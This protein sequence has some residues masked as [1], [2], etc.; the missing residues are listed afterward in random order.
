[1]SN[2]TTSDELVLQS[3]SP[4]EFDKSSELFYEA[5]RLR[6]L[7]SNEV[8]AEK[9]YREAMEATGSYGVFYH[10]AQ[11]QIYSMLGNIEYA[12][13]EFEIA[14]EINDQ[15]DSVFID[16][17]LTYRKIA[18]RLRSFNLNDKA[19]A[20][21]KESV[22]ALNRAIGINP[23]NA[24][25]WSA[26]ATTY[27]KMGKEYLDKAGTCITRARELDPQ[28]YLALTNLANLRQ[29][30]GN[31]KEA[32]QYA[33]AAIEMRPN[34]AF[35]YGTIGRIEYIEHRFKEAIDWFEK[36]ITIEPNNSY[37]LSEMGKAYRDVGKFQGDMRSC[38]EAVNWF[39]KA[40]KADQEGDEKYGFLGNR[41]D[42]YRLAG[43]PALAETDLKQALRIKP[44]HSFSLSSLRD[45]YIDL[46]RHEEA[47]HLAK[48]VFE[49]S[50]TPKNHKQY[51]KLEELFNQDKYKSV[52]ITKRLINSNADVDSAKTR[53][54]AEEALRLYSLNHDA[55]GTLGR[56]HAAA[57]EFEAARK[58]LEQALMLNPGRSFYRR[59]L[60][61]VLEKLGEWRAAE[62]EYRAYIARFPH[63]EVCKDGLRR[64]KEHLQQEDRRKARSVTGAEIVF[65]NN[66]TGR[67]ERHPIALIRDFLYDRMTGWNLPIREVIEQIGD[68]PVFIIAKTGVG[69]TVTVPT[70]VLLGLCDNLL[71]EGAD[72]AQRFPQVYVVEPRIPICSMTMAE[73]NDGYQNYVAYRMTDYPEFRDYLVSEGVENVRSKEQNDVSKIVEL[74][75]K[76]VATGKAPYDPHHFNLYGCIT[77]A[78]G[79]INADA[80]I[81]FIT[82]GIME[83]L[84]FEGTELDPKYH[85]II[86]DEAHVTIEAN[87]AIEL[88]IALARKR[89]VKI[90]YMSAT[91]DPAT[92]S[93]DLGVKIVYAEAQR[94]PIHLTNLKAT[95]EES[96]LDLVENFLLN[97]DESRF[98]DPRDFA[99]PLVRAKVERVRLHLL[100]LDDVAD[101]GRIYPGLRNRPQ[102]MLVIVNSHQSENSDTHRIADLIA[103]AEFNRG[104]TRVH[105]LRL[106]SPVVRDP[107]QKLAFDRL[108][109]SIED[110]NGRYVIVATNVVEMGLTFSSLDYVVTMDA[111]FDSEFVDGSQMIRKVELGVNA[112]YQR[113]GRVGRVRPGMAF[114]ARD[115]GASYCA[116]DDETLAAGLPIAPI[117]Y[118]LAKGSF[119]KLALYSFRERMSEKDLRQQIA[120]LNL[121]SRIQENSELWSRFLAERSRLRRIGVAH[122]EG[123]TPAGQAALRFIGLDDMDFAY[124]LATVIER[125]GT[126]SDLAVIF[127]VI[128]ASSE[129]GFED[130]MARRFFL[131]NPKQLSAMEIFHED[132]LGVSVSEAYDLIKQYEFDPRRLHEALQ[133]SGV[134]EQLCSDIC[135]FVRAGYKLVKREDVEQ[136]VSVSQGIPDVVIP[137]EADSFAESEVDTPED[138]AGGNEV[139]EDLSDEVKSYLN[140]Y[141]TKHTLAFERAVVSFSDQS[142]LINTY[143]IYRHFFNNYFSRLRPG[144]L[145][146]LEASEVRRSMEEEASKLQLSVRALSGLN[147]RFNQL[148]KELARRVGIKLIKEETRLASDQRL[149]EEDRS[150]LRDSVIRD[151]LFEREGHDERFDLCI[152]YFKLV[153]GRRKLQPNDFRRVT[154]QLENFGFDVTNADVKELWFLI[155]RE[156]EQR[157]SNQLMRF[158]LK[159]T[160]EVLP[161]VSK[162][163]ERELLGLVKDVGYHRRLSFSRTNFGFTTEVR[164]QYGSTVEISFSDENSPFASTLKGKDRIT[165]FAKLT[166]QMISKAIRD[167][168]NESGFTKQDEKGF[169][170]SHVTLL[171]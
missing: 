81:L 131:T 107:S 57:G 133:S 8:A 111:E 137:D 32:R 144:A 165:V 171:G 6:Y 110:G 91:V 46:G 125:Y 72:L 145:S 53:R 124:L 157:Y 5:D 86:I 106:A 118:P 83:S 45:L 20:M 98:P 152:R 139:D 37:L 169:R 30:Q 77:S 120:A 142:E 150:I 85:R 62:R 73:M 100:S 158:E 43:E 153:E 25:A 69:K 64:V 103:R 24:G 71:N 44:D 70:K 47:F 138:E 140:R 123:L 129:F 121:P 108:I 115:F 58:H 78:T 87:P 130:L 159:E 76:F 13:T 14:S 151:L 156:A 17:G 136:E 61:R 161:P 166:P 16:L 122:D 92:L 7:G 19:D 102:G 50:N 28:S 168:G 31:K 149:S 65:L 82:T 97:P 90:D 119:L 96:I 34:L 113:V 36:A 9:K 75:I 99:D 11:G 167:E 170:L 35:A 112:L 154:E 89:G 74:A 10:L 26:L 38:K 93:T 39:D 116:L 105:T 40:L 59:T 67:E 128:A 88:G 163:L 104:M 22:D 141:S 127:V 143:R 55:W 18:G 51:K 41:G 94:F 29:R 23:N 42:A 4:Q 3:E 1:M 12:L 84:T 27:L 80:P 117:R 21:I 101:G 66:K 60:G 114:I 15:I 68:E 54:D 33:L 2:L 63:D 95:V 146:A 126:E 147:D 132:A 52:G 148:F 162:G 79:K 49:I 109:R 164:D 160:R 56:C 134:D 135:S 155:V 48:E